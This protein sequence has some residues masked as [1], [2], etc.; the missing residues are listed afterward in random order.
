MVEPPTPQ[1]A[2]SVEWVCTTVTTDTSHDRRG[3]Q[4]A[5]GLKNNWWPNGK[6]LKVGFLDGTTAQQAAVKTYAPEWSKSAN[7]GLAFPAAG[8]FD[9][10]ISFNANNGAWS[11]V[12]TDCIGVAAQYP[13]MNL[14]WQSADVI[15]HEF[16]HALGLMHEQQ[17][18]FGGICWDTAQ[19]IQSLS[20]PPNNWSVP[21][22]YW[23]VITP[24]NVASVIGNAYDPLSI[25]HYGIP[26]AWTCNK[27]AIA[28][29]KVLSPSDKIFIAARYPGPVT[30]PVVWPLTP[31]QIQQV[32]NG[33]AETKT[34]LDS[35]AARLA[36]S[37]AR[38]KKMVGQ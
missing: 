11:Y 35:T 25:M 17:S 27:K 30:P 18:P 26:S 7:I 9:I 38:F 6:I 1:P 10:R 36:R 12:G 32:L 8:P 15:W 21:M 5:V 24:L 14:G 28:G 34:A 4:R 22:I 16:G 31:A 20:G 2:A 33:Q 37:T 13:T 3:V 29:G 19:V 23:N